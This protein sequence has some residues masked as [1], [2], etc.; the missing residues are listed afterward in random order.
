MIYAYNA[1]AVYVG[2]LSLCDTTNSMGL[3]GEVVMLGRRRIDL[4]TVFTQLFLLR[5]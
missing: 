5:H 3:P 1:L 4:M 2:S